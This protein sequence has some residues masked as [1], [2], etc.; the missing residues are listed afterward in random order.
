[1]LGIIGCQTVASDYDQPARISNPTDASR[2]ALQRVVNAAL[3][4][5]VTLA[6]DA[7]SDTSVLII[8]RSPPRSMNSPPAQ[9][10]IMDAPIQFHLVLNGGDCILIDQRDESR[11]VL[12]ET[13]CVAE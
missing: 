1:M 8:E 4:T 6:D 3:H 11:H 10:R 9:G 7:L 5:E 12:E 13:D 2:A